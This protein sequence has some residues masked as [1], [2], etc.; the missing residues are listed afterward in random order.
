MTPSHMASPLYVAD[1]IRVNSCVFHR[2][3][4]PYCKYSINTN[5][6]ADY[7]LDG[8]P[9]ISNARVKNCFHMPKKQFSDGEIIAYKNSLQV[10]KLL[11]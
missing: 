9:D 4:R 2:L 3:S 8:P 10:K 5:S 1:R 6:L 11:M 7:I